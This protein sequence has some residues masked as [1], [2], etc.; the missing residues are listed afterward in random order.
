M[1]IKNTV[2]SQ[3]RKRNINKQVSYKGV[4]PEKAFS[5]LANPDSLAR[6]ITLETFVTGGRSANAYKRGG[7]PEFRETFTDNLISAIF[8]MKGVDMCNKAGDFIGKNVLKLPTTDFDVGKDALRTP[9]NNIAAEV[10]KN[11]TP[12]NAKALEKKL[13]VFKFSKIIA[14]TLIATGFVGF[15]LPKINQAITRSMMNSKLKDAFK[16]NKSKANTSSLVQAYSMESFNKQIEKRNKETNPSFKGLSPTAM[17]TVAHLLENNPIVKMLTCDVGILAGRVTTARNADEGREY[18]FRDATSSFFYMAS[19]PLV[20]KGLQKLTN[21]SALTSID[22]VTAKQLNEG[23]INL[24]KDSEGKITSMQ[25]KDFAQKA[26]G[27][28]TD[29]GK[30]ILSQLK[31]EPE[32]IS[33]ERLREFVSDEKLLA[34]AREMAKLQPEQAGVGAVLT[35]QQ[36]RDVLKGGDVNAPSFLKKLYQT[37]FGEAL[38]N[39]YKYI[40]MKKITKFKDN[41]DNYTQ[42]VVK[43][44]EKNGGIVDEKLLNGMRKKS[45]AMSAG[46]RV[47]ALGFSALML[48][49]VIPK[50]QHKMTEKR[51]GTNAAP[52]LREFEQAEKKA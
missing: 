32:V 21:S 26:I 20:Y 16:E 31:S 44:A 36:I 49:L 39:P 5:L 9:F 28:M 51:T 2:P 25:A 17:T 47:V 35:K 3:E 46:F 8:W 23:M 13:A 50:L 29:K 11:L 27:A 42:A 41:I 43:A 34:R 37:K 30:E 4:T 18:L 14:S 12:E 48:G 52:G 33:V 10:G 1:R 45:F 7:F 40:S 6:T 15:I 24:L 22:P 38:T 19:T